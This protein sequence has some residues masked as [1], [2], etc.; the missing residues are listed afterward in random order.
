MLGPMGEID[1]GG[2]TCQ[3]SIRPRAIVKEMVDAI[4]YKDQGFSS[5]SD[6]AS[7]GTVTVAQDDALVFGIYS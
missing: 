3:P 5:A 7:I 2:Q 1:A 4:F 6:I